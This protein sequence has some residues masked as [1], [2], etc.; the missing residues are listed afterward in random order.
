MSRT[1][2]CLHRIAIVADDNCLDAF[3]LEFIDLHI[4]YLLS[5]SGNDSGIGFIVE[6]EFASKSNNIK[7]S[8]RKDN[9]ICRTL[10]NGIV[11][12]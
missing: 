4:G 10:T 9:S 12:I 2:Y 7:D 5:E 8:L 6:L 3:A 1:L 11:V